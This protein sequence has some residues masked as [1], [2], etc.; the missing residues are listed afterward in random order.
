MGQTKRTNKAKKDQELKVSQ[1]KVSVNTAD[2][3][4][5]EENKDSS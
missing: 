5:R 4:G 3:L 1:N 2:K